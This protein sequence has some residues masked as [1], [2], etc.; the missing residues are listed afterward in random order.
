MTNPYEDS[1]V[2]DF[3]HDQLVDVLMVAL[4]ADIRR[5]LL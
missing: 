1:S 2:V 5:A 3:P 4:E